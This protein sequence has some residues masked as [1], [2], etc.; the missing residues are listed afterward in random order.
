MQFLE[1]M[2]Y[3][4]N[5]IYEMAY[6]AKPLVIGFGIFLFIMFLVLL[7]NQVK[8]DKLEKKVDL[9]LERNDQMDV[10][11]QGLRGWLKK[12]ASEGWKKGD[13]QNE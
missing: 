7:A 10:Y 9:L 3:V 12:Q 1:D 4:I 2:E 5:A 6:F 13:K 8:I 11:F